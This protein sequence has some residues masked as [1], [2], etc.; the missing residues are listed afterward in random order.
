M[1]VDYIVVGLGL[2]GLAFCRKLEENGKSFL[3]FENS[4]QNAS[5]V[6]GGVYNPII[7]KRFSKVWDAEDQLDHALPFYDQLEKHLDNK[8]TFPTCIYRIF[9]SYEEQNNWTA[10]SDRPF[11]NRFMDPEIYKNSVKGISADFGFGKMMNTGRIS[12]AD[13]I[14]DY[15]KKLAASGQIRFEKFQY[16]ELKCL[17]S[18]VEYADI[19]AG[20]VV[21]CDGFGLKKN[22]FF[23][24]LPLN[25]TKGELLEIHAPDLDIDFMIKAAVFILPMGSNKYKIGATF[26]WK[27]KN[28]TPTAEGRIE[29]EKKLKSFFSGKYTVLNHLAGVRPTVKDRRPLVGSHPNFRNM[30]VL[31]G[32][33]TRGVMIA[34]KAATLLF[35]HLEFENDVPQEYGISRFQ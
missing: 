6:A 14:K 16:E 4:S 1:Q 26:N 29:L 10:I 20:K 34:P 28:S 9:K 21:F 3:V 18:T 32:L 11:F 13:L 2:A 27:E 22:P 8:Y 5:H 17:K 31:N 24:T 12:V 15:Q 35:E 25:G 33:G 19:S 7:L 30:G 23:K